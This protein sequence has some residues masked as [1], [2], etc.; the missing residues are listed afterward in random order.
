M[1]T[2]KNFTLKKEENEK[3][4]MWLEVDEDQPLKMKFRPTCEKQDL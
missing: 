1:G 2:E 4:C 3:S